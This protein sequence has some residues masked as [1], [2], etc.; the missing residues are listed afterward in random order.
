MI[1]PGTYQVFLL[2]VRIDISAFTLR[3]GLS[4]ISLPPGRLL[5]FLFFGH[6]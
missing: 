6:H 4:A 5:L 1:P 2:L 3:L